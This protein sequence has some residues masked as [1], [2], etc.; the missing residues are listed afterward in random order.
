MLAL[1]V[2]FGLIAISAPTVLPLVSWFF[3]LL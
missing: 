1:L 3:S 2:V